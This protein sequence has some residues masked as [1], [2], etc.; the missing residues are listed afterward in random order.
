MSKIGDS[1]DDYT[2][3]ANTL[4]HFMHES[5][6]LKSILINRAIIPRYCIE[7][8]E[9]LHI[10]NK[11]VNYK[12]VA[13][14]QKCFCDI[15][16][17]KITDTFELKGVGNVYQSLTDS[18]KYSLEKNNSH[19]AFYGKFAIAFSKTWGENKN[20]Q[21]IH[22]LNEKSLYT[23]SFIRL[24]NDIL[25]TDN[26]SEEYAR[27][28]LNRLLFIKPLRGIIKRVIKRNNPENDTLEN[29]SIEFYKNFHDEQ[30]WRY[31]PDPSILSTLKLECM[32]ANP[33]I[34]NISDNIKRI[35]NSLEKEN[36]RALWLEYN[37]N[38][39]RYIIVPDLRSRNEIINTIIDIP[40]KQFDGQSDVLIQ[41]YALISKILVLEEIRKDL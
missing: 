40:D 21:P 33:K 5:R 8:F 12:E 16:L 39:I 14:L 29:I 7:N 1:F 35:N 38:D 3:S 28:V 24:L 22:Y 30:E 4:F 15:P 36:F 6:Y 17:H 34:I 25:N 26:I 11:N 10:H 31:I 23:T 2:Q 41:K 9:Y 32:I 13:I 18:E 19:P 20:F 37:Y 27:Y